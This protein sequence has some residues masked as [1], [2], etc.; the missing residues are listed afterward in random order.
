MS[1]TVA[2]GFFEQGDIESLCLDVGAAPV[3]ASVEELQ[4]L[5]V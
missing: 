5:P 2:G 3:S 1:R 4:V